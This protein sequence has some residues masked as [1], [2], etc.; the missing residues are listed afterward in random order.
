MMGPTDAKTPNQAPQPKRINVTLSQSGGKVLIDCVDQIAQLSGGP[1]T[2]TRSA[3]SAVRSEIEMGLGLRSD[4]TPKVSHNFNWGQLAYDLV[5]STVAMAHRLEP[6]NPD[7][8]FRE[9]LLKR[10]LDADPVTQE[11]KPVTRGG[12]R[13]NVVITDKLKE[14]VAE[15]YRIAAA[16]SVLD[17]TEVSEDQTGPS[18]AGGTV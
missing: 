3:L 4:T 10:L 8:D 2:I 9:A 13:G 16:I 5:V 15:L 6:K 12:G 18:L 14:T 7:S 1:D 17:N 11:V